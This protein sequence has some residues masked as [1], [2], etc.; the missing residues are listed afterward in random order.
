[1]ARRRFLRVVAV[2]GAA[3]TVGGAGALQAAPRR[4]RVSRHRMRLGDGQ[5]LRVVQLTDLHL[6]RATPAALLRQALGAAH[7]ARPDLVVM[8]GDYLNRTLRYLPDLDRL[9]ARLPRPCVATLG[10][11]DHWSG[12]E[13]IARVLG[14]RGITVLRN[15]HAVLRLRGRELTVVGVD[16]GTTGHADVARALAGVARP[17]TALVLT[18]NPRTAEEI[19]LRGARL[20]L[21]GHTHGGQIAIPRLTRALARAGGMRYLSGWYPVGPGRLYVS[22]GVGSAVFRLRLGRRAAPEAAVFELS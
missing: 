10:N 3:A 9:A 13:A 2:T 21:A 4:L 16:D 6:G 11:H 14:R 18:H 5:P 20:V 7:R 8:T 17:E 12:A 15:S 19:V 22:P 1:M